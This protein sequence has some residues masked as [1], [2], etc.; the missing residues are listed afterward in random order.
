[1]SN[2]Q[3]KQVR[4]ILKGK[5][6]LRTNSK[7]S[8]TNYDL[9]K[10]SRILLNSSEFEVISLRYLGI[11]VN[12]YV[13]VSMEASLS[14]SSVKR[15]EAKGLN[16]ILR[17][18]QDEYPD[19]KYIRSG[20][21]F[22]LYS[23]E[24]M[25]AIE[26]VENQWEEMDILQRK[27]RIREHIEN[28]K[29][30]DKRESEK[31]WYEENLRLLDKLEDD[32][33]EYFLEIHHRMTMIYA[34]D[35][36]LREQLYAEDGGYNPEEDKK[37]WELKQ[38]G[39]KIYEECTLEE[40]YYRQYE[41]AKAEFIQDA[42]DDFT[43]IEDIPLSCF[44]GEPIDIL[45]KLKKLKGN[46]LEKYIDTLPPIDLTEDSID[47]GM[48]PAERY[49]NETIKSLR[50]ALEV[51]GNEE[52]ARMLDN[53]L[54]K[55]LGFRGDYDGT[56]V[57]KKYSECTLKEKVKRQ[58]NFHEDMIGDEVRDGGLDVNLLKAIYEDVHGITI[59]EVI[60]NLTMLH[61]EELESFLETLP[62]IGEDISFIEKFRDSLKRVEDDLSSTFECNDNPVHIRNSDTLKDLEGVMLAKELGLVSHYDGVG[63]GLSYEECSIEEKIERQKR[64]YSDLLALKWERGTYNIRAL[65][66]VVQSITGYV[67]KE[68]IEKL[69][70]LEGERI[71]NVLDK[72]IPIGSSN[73]SLAE[74][75][76]Y[77][78][79]K[80]EDTYMFALLKFSTGLSNEDIFNIQVKDIKKGGRLYSIFNID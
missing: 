30:E 41:L 22:M 65:E 9:V 44:E 2:I 24:I 32:K 26:R 6:H 63:F 52:G 29:H 78:S 61:G 20:E 17:V 34:E 27:E 19:A 73:Y 10:E 70:T 18:V 69:T 36:I 74:K 51:D 16:K 76:K 45:I 47:D 77:L 12:S 35:T 49:L 7:K 50:K 68:I 4:S 1:M 39:Y 21:L 8:L 33:L 67:F 55:S 53:I 13:K 62:P 56:G 15:I 11:G 37:K 3:R 48:T 31:W 23:D 54:T 42:D 60:T 71:N 58:L 79:K 14:E 80:E 40:K 72:L 28:K 59:Q 43:D 5:A 38:G 75:F 46:E 57:E 64:L 25:E 66:S